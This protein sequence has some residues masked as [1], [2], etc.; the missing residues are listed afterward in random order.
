MNYFHYLLIEEKQLVH[1]IPVSY[2]LAAQW[3]IWAQVFFTGFL[4]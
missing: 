3:V 2:G 4:L 1:H